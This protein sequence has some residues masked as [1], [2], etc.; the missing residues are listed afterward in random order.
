VSSITIK[1]IAKA[2]NIS[3]S[4]VSRALRDSYDIKP[5]TKKLVVEYAEK[6]NYRPNPIALSLKENRSRSIGVVVP[7]IA[8]NFFSQAINGIEDVAYQRGYHVVI[9]QS[10]E[11]LERE[12]SNVHHLIARRVDGLLISLSGSTSDIS[13]IDKYQLP[14]VYFD[15]VPET[16]GVN[17][18]VVDNF[19]GAYKATEYLIHQGKTRIAHITS[20]PILSIT[21][22]RVAGYKAA[23]ENNGIAVNNDL[24]KYSGF[25]QEEHEVILE[26]LL[27]E[28]NPDAFFMASDRLA[29]GCF[30]AFKKLR[31]KNEQNIAL[32]GFTNL[33]V[34]HLLEPPLSTVTQPAFKIGQTA[35]GILLD[36]IENKHK[37][38]PKE[39]VKL[40]TELNIRQ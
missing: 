18:V 17:K 31:P 26:K 7:E 16:E 8:N 30:Q 22:E 34:A 13:Y 32:I 23:L 40:Y 3:T 19:E 39:T 2:L 11:S 10:H 9:F 21:R 27:Q 14:V 37:G 5:E 15:R 25:G 20:P 24:I 1:D 6:M 12:T 28:Q 33:N 29:L 35:A 36:E 4:T 38:K